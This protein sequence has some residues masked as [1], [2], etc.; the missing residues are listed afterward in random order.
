MKN[1]ILAVD[2]LLNL[3]WENTVRI[4]SPDGTDVSRIMNRIQDA[5]DEIDGRVFYLP[6]NKEGELP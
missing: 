5:R 6:E 1:L 3:D 4:H 2:E